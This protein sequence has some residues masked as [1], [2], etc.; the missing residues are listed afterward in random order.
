MADR[1]SA[2]DSAP[3]RSERLVGS[4][5]FH[6][7]VF[8]SVGDPLTLIFKDLQYIVKVKEY[9]KV[10][11]PAH[12]EKPKGFFKRIKRKKKG[13]SKL[14]EKEIL[15]T[16]T[17]VFRPGRLTAIMGASGA[18]KTS[19]LTVLAGQAESGKVEGIIQ[20]NGEDYSE[21]GK[22]QEIS[23]FVFQD[24]VLLPTMTV[25][26]AIN[27]SAILRLP[28]SVT[29][30]ERNRRVEEIIEILHLKKAAKTKVGDP[31]K[32]GISG[33]ERKRTSSHD[34][35]QD[36]FLIIVLYRHCYGNHY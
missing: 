10:E 6:D 32:K 5:D 15:K 23:G 11:E 29:K 3:D 20:I 34:S 17:G 7:S 28:S 26:E 24:D 1:P 18:G 36:K 25:Q 8:A 9:Q 2:S 27:Q 16:L 22:M 21:A 4:G 33:G 35:A 31:L 30:E 13:K 12:E 14:V 19:L